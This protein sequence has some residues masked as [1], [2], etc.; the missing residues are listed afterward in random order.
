MV[1]ETIKRN[2]EIYNRLCYNARKELEI[3]PV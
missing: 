1:L 2:V 3:D